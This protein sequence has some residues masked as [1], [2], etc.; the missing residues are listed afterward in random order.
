[1]AIDY[2]LKRHLEA[3]LER[4]FESRREAITDG[5][6]KTLEEYGKRCGYLHAL[7]DIGSEIN[8]WVK[9]VND[10]S[11]LSKIKEFGL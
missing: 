3:W 8:S 6:C 1:M 5:S 11:L 4:E 2:D 9:S 7:R 10:D